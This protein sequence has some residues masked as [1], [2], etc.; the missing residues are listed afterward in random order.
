MYL[1][2]LELSLEKNMNIN[3]ISQQELTD[4]IEELADTF[5][6]RFGYPVFSR[7]N[8]YWKPYRNYVFK[9]DGRRFFIATQS[10]WNEHQGFDD[11]GCDVH[12]DNSSIELYG[13]DQVME[14][15]FTFL[16]GS[17]QKGK[18]QLIKLGMTEVFD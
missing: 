9:V 11:T 3:Q 16:L 4:Y 13:F 7:D 10:Y 12:A 17:I 1:A 15:C 2:S 8:S 6:K 14:S 5:N 18:Q